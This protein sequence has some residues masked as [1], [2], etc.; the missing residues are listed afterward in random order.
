MREGLLFLGGRETPRRNEKTMSTRSKN[1]PIGTS[2]LDYWGQ[3]IID[4]D[5][6]EMTWSWLV[7]EPSGSTYGY[8]SGGY[9]A[10]IRS[11]WSRVQMS[12]TDEQCM[13]AFG[14]VPKD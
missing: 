14:F 11:F 4:E 12:L 6:G 1:T 10:G 2:H 9:E 3:E 5:T 8:F 7:T 13:A